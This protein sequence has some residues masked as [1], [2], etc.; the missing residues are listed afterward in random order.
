MTT[1]FNRIFDNI[2][3]PFLLLLI[4]MVMGVGNVWADTWDG[5]EEYLHIATAGN[6]DLGEMVVARWVLWMV[7]D[8]LL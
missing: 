7:L 8:N 2:Y 1:T 3:R 6:V 5:T 4:M